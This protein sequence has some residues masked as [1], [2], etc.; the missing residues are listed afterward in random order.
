MSATA[1][2]SKPLV[3]IITP[4]FN[5]AEFLEETLLSVLNQ[6][7]GNVEYLVVDGA[8]T[9]GSA[10]IIEKYAERLSWWVSEPDGGQAEAINKGMQRA[11]GEIVAWLNSDDIYYP[12]AIAQAVNAL[13]SNPDASMVYGNLDSIRRDG[14]RFNT[15]RY[16]P[17]S[18]DELLSFRML[19]QPSVFM[20]RNML[21]QVGLLDQEYQFLLDHHLWIR[22]A[23]QGNLV[24]VNETWA[25]A[26]HHSGAKNRAKAAGF[27]EEAR[28]ILKW[29]DTN[30]NL[31]P[32]V[33]HNLN[34]HLGAANRLDGRYLLEA[35]KHWSALNA[36]LL[37]FLSSPIELLRHWRRFLLALLSAMG[38][39][40]LRP[41]PYESLRPVLVTGMHRSGTSW[42]GRMLNLSQRTA[43]ISEPLNMLHRRGVLD[44]EVKHWYQ[45][46]HN[47]K[48]A[49]FELAFRRMLKL[50]YKLGKEM[51]SLRSDRDLLRMMRDA[52]V[53][54][55]GRIARQRPLIKDPFALFSVPWFLD[56]LDC[57]VVIVVRHPAAAVSSLKRLGWNFDFKDLLAQDKLMEDWLAP[58][59]NEIEASINEESSLVEQGALLWRMLYHTA[60]QI[61]E[62]YPAVRL[63]RH[64]DLSRQPLLE[65]EQLYLDLELPFSKHAQ[66]GIERATQATN[67]EEVSLRSIYATKL[68][69]LANL[70]NWKKRLTEEEISRI[71][72]I[73]SDVAELYYAEEE[74]D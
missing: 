46:V 14:S 74:W 10:A 24:H 6:D 72:E 37:A 15:I 8:S 2:R 48:H 33:Q 4:S 38:L 1:S 20:R 9:D 35:G 25:A 70:F 26:R 39:G 3:S 18:L 59:R 63:V 16:Q 40:W 60:H 53:F 71:R 21:K 64:E 42:V 34:R 47:V 30:K 12:D 41:E 43:Y 44:L 36:Y 23:K 13:N 19:G 32:Y 69:S 56:E 57:E 67:P 73:T 49:E 31:A 45:Y 11:K 54:L 68:D 50:R 22:L 65:F 52:F 55:R 61:K 66:R 17:Y 7:Y 58:F 27:G 29:A 28:R 62:R 5:Q 51:L